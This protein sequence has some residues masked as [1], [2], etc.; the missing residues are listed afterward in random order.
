MTPTARKTFR[1]ERWRAPLEGMLEPVWVPLALLIA[2]RHFDAPA[3]LKSLLVAAGFIGLLLTPFSLSLLSRWRGTPT[4]LVAGIAGLS[5]LLLSLAVWAR[6][7]GWFVAAIVSARILWVQST[8]LM[9]H[10]F[11]ANYDA[12]DRGRLFAV[13]VVLNAIG[14][15][16][17]S[18]GGGTWLDQDISRYPLVLLL[19]VGCA[20]GN[21]LL[22]R[23]LPAP[24]RLS[25][26][27]RNPLSHLSLVWRDRLFGWV[28]LSWMILGIGNL[29][30]VPLRIEYLA[31]E[32]YGLELGE[33]EIMLL[34]FAL[35]V[36]VRILASQVWGRLFDHLNFVWWRIAVN[37]AFVASFLIFFNSTTLWGLSAGMFCLGFAMAGGYIG[38]Q[39]WVTKLAPPD[40]VSAYMSVHT[41]CTGFRGTLAPFLAYPLASALGPGGVAWFSAILVV[42]SSIMM[43]AVLGSPRWAGERL[44]PPAE[45]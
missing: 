13:A 18:A 1:L 17:A 21:A 7:L 30:T 45:V 19:L 11:A 10:T 4:L 8:P 39:L 34:T 2:I 44:R 14:G 32:E 24:P 43:A 23:A 28:L 29:V 12:S 3:G 31:A 41:F 33:T 25:A 22:V 40:Q 36:G 38:W 6:D 42:L 27:P 35:P 37:V 5:G 15:V 26:P 9:T 20:W 16:I